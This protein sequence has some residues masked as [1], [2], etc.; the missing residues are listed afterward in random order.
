MSLLIPIIKMPF[1]VDR[2]TAEAS[3]ETFGLPESQSD[4][5]EIEKLI[6]QRAK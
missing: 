2:F 1:M 6:Q 3:P 4:V 5:E